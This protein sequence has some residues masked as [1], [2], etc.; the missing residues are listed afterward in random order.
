MPD[1]RSTDLAVYLQQCADSGDFDPR[2]EWCK[3]MIPTSSAKVVHRVSR[4][5][6]SWDR[7]DEFWVEE[8]F[9]NRAKIMVQFFSSNFQF[10]FTR[11]AKISF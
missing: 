6:T 3:R 7:P 8:T 11:N 4:A 10:F 5:G 2:F 1:W 9:E